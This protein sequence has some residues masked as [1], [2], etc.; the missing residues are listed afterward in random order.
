[1]LL[2]GVVP[3]KFTKRY[4][5]RPIRAWNFVEGYALY[6]AMIASLQKAN[7]LIEEQAL[8]IEELSKKLLSA[9]R[10]I[11][12]LQHQVDQLLRRIYGRRS[13]K[14]HPDQLMFD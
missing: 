3:K 10:T 9:Q 8:H 1:M 6:T 11:K 12:M 2:E 5:Y 7:E 13:E 4:V 14:R